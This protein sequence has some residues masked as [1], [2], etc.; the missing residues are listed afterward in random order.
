MIYDFAATPVAST[1]VSKAFGSSIAISLNIFLFRAML[2]FL[3]P[4][5]NSL[6]LIPRWRHAALNLVIHKPRKS[7]F[8]RLLSIRALTFARTPASF[9]SRYSLPAA[10]RWP[11]TAF[12]IRFLAW[13]LAAPFLTL[14]ISAFL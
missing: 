2:A 12:K 6:Y 5:M 14:G 3:Q 10:P 9:A 8:L 1:I 7:R 11:F 13:R 4:L